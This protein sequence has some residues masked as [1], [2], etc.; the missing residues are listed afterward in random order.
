[1]RSCLFTFLVWQQLE[2]LVFLGRRKLCWLIYLLLQLSLCISAGWRLQP[3][4]W[5]LK[6]ASVQFRPC[7]KQNQIV[8]ITRAY[9]VWWSWSCQARHHW[10]LVLISARVVGELAPL[11]VKPCRTVHYKNT[12]KT[13]PQWHEFGGVV[14]PGLPSCCTL[15]LYT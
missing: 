14:R 11:L 12:S 8:L 2:H 5:L 15:D 13:P 1:M 6:C 4:F 3:V 9:H 7:D 10:C